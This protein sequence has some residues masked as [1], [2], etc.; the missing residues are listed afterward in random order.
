MRTNNGRTLSGILYQSY[1]GLPSNSAIFF[2]LAALIA[3]M[4]K[5]PTISLFERIPFMVDT[6]II[7]NQIFKASVK[8]I[9]RL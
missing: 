4:R 8:E 5:F 3:C 1:S 6:F 2:S 7:W 9:L